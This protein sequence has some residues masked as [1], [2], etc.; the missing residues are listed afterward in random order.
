MKTTGTQVL[1]IAEQIVSVLPAGTF[2][3]VC[4][5]DRDTIRYA[6]RAEDVKLRSVVLSRGSLQRLATD[7]ARPVK[8]EYLQKEL[9]EAA[10]QRGEFRYPRTVRRASCTSVTRMAPQRLTPLVSGL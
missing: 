9:L 2:M 7:A 10:E 8:I 1:R 3:R 5:D 4:S 6:V